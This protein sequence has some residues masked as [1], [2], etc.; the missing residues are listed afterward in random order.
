MHLLPLQV[1]LL[2]CYAWNWRKVLT[3]FLARSV[4]SLSWRYGC[5]DIVKDFLFHEEGWA[6]LR[7]V[8]NGMLRAAHRFPWCCNMLF[9]VRWWRVLFWFDCLYIIMT[10]WGILLFQLLAY[11]YHLLLDVKVWLNKGLVEPFKDVINGKKKVLRCL[12]SINSVCRR[13]IDCK[14]HALVL[15]LLLELWV[16]DEL[17]IKEM[18]FG[19]GVFDLWLKL[20][21]LAHEIVGV[22]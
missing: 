6:V 1:S 19:W 11:H 10:G 8:D 2:V 12:W 3:C 16:F 7:N 14:E 20:D 13:Y 5:F 21:W 4:W 9:E 17:H 18:L 22:E 15:Q